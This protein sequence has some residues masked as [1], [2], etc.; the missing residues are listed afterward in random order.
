MKTDTKEVKEAIQ[1]TAKRIVA[2]WVMTLLS[3]FIALRLG[4]YLS[5][6]GFLG[7][8]LLLVPAFALYQA[9]KPWIRYV[10]YGE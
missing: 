9:W 5:V 3:C 6:Y 2:G 7:L 1:R 8:M 4:A 10:F